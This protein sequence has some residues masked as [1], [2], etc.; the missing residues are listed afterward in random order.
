MFHLK[1]ISFRVCVCKGLKIITVRAGP[2]AQ[3]LSS[4]AL[5]WQ[6]RVSPVRTPG[7]NLAPLIRPCGGGVHIA[8]L[9]PTTRMYNYELGGFGEK[10]KKKKDWP[11][12]L[13]QRQY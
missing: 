5:L 8:E 2:V 3:G 12:M 11:Q 13:A 9:G 4:C 1:V 7:T 10:R 6:P